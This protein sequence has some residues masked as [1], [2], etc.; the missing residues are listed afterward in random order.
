MNSE[1]TTLCKF[2]GK[3]FEVSV[4]QWEHRLFTLRWASIPARDSGTDFEHYRSF[5]DAHEA[6]V[7]L[8]R[9]AIAGTGL[10]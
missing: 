8:G 10:L 4:R 6:G 5:N 3:E 9:A 1:T 7:R 2:L